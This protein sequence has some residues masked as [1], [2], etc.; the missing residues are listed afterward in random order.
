LFVALA[1]YSKRPTLVKGLAHL[2][3]IV[4]R[5][6]FPANPLL[7]TIRRTKRLY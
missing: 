6:T 5:Q 2:T 3:S 4:M 7:S 1:F